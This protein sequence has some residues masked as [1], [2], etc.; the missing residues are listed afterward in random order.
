MLNTKIGTST[1]TLMLAPCGEYILD[2]SIP[3]INK[4]TIGTTIR[5]NPDVFINNLKLLILPLGNTSPSP[6]V[7]YPVP[8]QP[9][10]V[11]TPF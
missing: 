1:A 11:F 2:V 9:F 6:G 8:I 3:T 4:S 10:P 5:Y 7:V